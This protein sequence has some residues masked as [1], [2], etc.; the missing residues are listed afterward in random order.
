MGTS[1]ERG[2]P[3]RELHHGQAST[4]VASPSAGQQPYLDIDWRITRL[5]L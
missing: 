2:W 4:K 1:E 5:R 3:I